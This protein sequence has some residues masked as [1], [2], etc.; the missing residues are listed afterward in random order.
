MKEFVWSTADR[1]RLKPGLQVLWRNE[2]MQEWATVTDHDPLIGVAGGVEFIYART[3]SGGAPFLKYCD[4]ASLRE[5]EQEG[6]A[7]R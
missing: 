1:A 7:L 4:P 3:P 5:A 2:T 6:K